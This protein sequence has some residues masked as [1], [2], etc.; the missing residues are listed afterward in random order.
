MR[1]REHV[2]VKLTARER[3][4]TRAR[5]AVQ[6][7]L[8]TFVN[9][10][11]Q[12]KQL[13]LRSLMMMMGL[14][15]SSYWLI[16]WSFDALISHTAMTPFWALG[17]AVGL[18]YFRRSVGALFFVFQVWAQLQV[19]IGVLLSCAFNRTRT[20]SIVT[21]LLVIGSAVGA[22]ILWQLSLAPTAPPWNPAFDAYPLFA[23]YHCVFLAS[24]KGL[25]VRALVDPSEPVCLAFWLMV[26]HAAWVLPLGLYLDA[27][28]PR[29][30]GLPSH[31][32]FCAGWCFRKRVGV[33]TDTG[34][35]VPKSRLNREHV[36]ET[37]RARPRAPCGGC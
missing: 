14:P 31:P 35:P 26:V 29:E 25:T 1:A 32:L 4:P 13:K 23:Y 36:P 27:I 12:E 34:G 33:G 3:S 15:A 17:A 6:M 20:A 11:V 16:E 21:Y 28:L 37:V 5:R 8:P 2:R 9:S 24:Q 30:F 18:R 10:V 22:L 7:L 19:A